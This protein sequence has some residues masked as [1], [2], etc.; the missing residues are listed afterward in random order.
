MMKFLLTA[1]VVA[2]AISLLIDNRKCIKSHEEQQTTM[3][4]ISQ[5]NYIFIPVWTRVCDQWE[6]SK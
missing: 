3:L 4:W 1:L 6:E 2:A 5:T